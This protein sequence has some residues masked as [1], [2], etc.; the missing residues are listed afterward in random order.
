MAGQMKPPNVLLSLE[1]SEVSL[2]PLQVNYLKPHSLG[3]P[4]TH[5]LRYS[6]PRNFNP[7]FFSLRNRPPISENIYSKTLNK[8]YVSDSLIMSTKCTINLLY[9]FKCKTFIYYEI[10]QFNS[11]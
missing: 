8:I 10:D 3:I 2:D 5:N 6:C 9:I 11:Y 4:K 1:K 7:F